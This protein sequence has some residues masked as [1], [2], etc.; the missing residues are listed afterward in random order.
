MA[1][2]ITGITPATGP[3]TGGTVHY[4]TGSDL[5]T[6]TGVTIGGAACPLFEAQSATLMKVTAP[7]SGTVGAKDVVLSPGAVTLAAAFTYAAPTGNEQLVPTKASKYVFEVRRVGDTAWTRVRAIA[8]FKPPVEANMET[9]SDYDGNGWGSEAKTELK[10]SIEA[11]LFRKVGI[12]S[13]T[14]DP[15]QE[16]LRAA[17]TK[18]GQD[19]VVE[20]RWYDR[21][22][23]PEAYQGFANVSW[24]PEGGDTKAL[25]MVTAKLSGNGERRDIVNPAA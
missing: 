20:A 6:V 9:D 23:G 13:S 18:F 21:N 17:S 1:I 24:E 5:T 3:T 15:G 22:G 10:W 4:I 16:I 12:S 8:D 25:D 14:Y 11:K 7:A 2:A 19:G